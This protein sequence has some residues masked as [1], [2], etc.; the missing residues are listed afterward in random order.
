SAARGPQDLGAISGMHRGS[1]ACG[2]PREPAGRD[3]VAIMW[4][5]GVPGVAMSEAKGACLGLCPLR[6][7]QGDSRRTP[8]EERAG[9]AV[10]PMRFG[11]RYAHIND[12][13]HAIRKNR[14]QLMVKL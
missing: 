5:R 7:A 9:V 4:R 6:S 14:H 2:R 3:N 13:M 12:R 11:V 10:P 8:R 1:H